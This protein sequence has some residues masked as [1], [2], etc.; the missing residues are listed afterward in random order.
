MGTSVV[1]GLQ[2]STTD[3]D[4]RSLFIVS[5]P[6]HGAELHGNGAQLLFRLCGGFPLLYLEFYC[7]VL[8]L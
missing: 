1:G 8:Q 5:V 7:S 3:G 4:V 2:T 6:H